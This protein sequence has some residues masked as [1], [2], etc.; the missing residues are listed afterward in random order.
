[1]YVNVNYS[2]EDM[3]TMDSKFTEIAKLSKGEEAGSGSDFVTRDIS[4]TFKTAKNAGFFI[5]RVKRFQSV[6]RVELHWERS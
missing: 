4:F 3:R 6:N 5:D 2:H 1:M